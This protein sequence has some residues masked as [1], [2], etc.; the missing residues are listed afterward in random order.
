MKI[1]NFTKY[2]SCLVFIAILF[3]SGTTLL[4]NH[5]IQMGINYDYNPVYITFVTIVCFGGIGTLL[6]L[7]KANFSEKN[8]KL[9]IDYTRLIILGLP[10]FIL[11]ATHVW[12]QLGLF[13][14]F[15]FVYMYILSN[16]YILIISSIILGH[17]LI[18]SLSKEDDPVAVQRDTEISDIT[19]R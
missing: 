7:S 4:H 8:K 5:Y 6:G 12:A 11:S 19:V 14:D 1:G 17:T 13:K 18:A 2:V 3:Y 9:K 16:D 10:T 15:V